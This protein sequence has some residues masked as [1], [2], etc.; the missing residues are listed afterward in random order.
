[1]LGHDDGNFVAEVELRVGGLSSFV[2]RRGAQPRDAEERDEFEFLLD[3][4]RVGNVVVGCV[5]DVLAYERRRCAG[6]TR[7]SSACQPIETSCYRN[8]LQGELISCW[9]VIFL[10]INCE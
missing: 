8:Q 6:S 1:M 10:E 3:F 5:L 7:V 9:T 2:L 4:M